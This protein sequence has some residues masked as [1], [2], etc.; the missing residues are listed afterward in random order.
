[1]VVLRCCR[2]PAQVERCLRHREVGVH[3]RRRLPQ[4]HRPDGHRREDRAVDRVHRPLALRRGSR[5][6]R[7]L[8]RC[9]G[10]PSRRLESP[11]A[12]WRRRRRQRHRRL[13][14]SALLRL[15]Q[16]TAVRRCSHELS[17]VHLARHEVDKPLP[18]GDLVEHTEE[19][20]E[21]VHKAGEVPVLDQPRQAG[22][23]GRGKQRPLQRRRG[24]RRHHRRRRLL[25]LRLR[26]LSWLRLQTG[27]G[28]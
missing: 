12:A 15:H 6:R 26:P 8:L 21:V 25:R 1:G 11:A 18:D 10:R 28:T 7:R 4:Q 14:P 27:S 23:R 19:P 16:R 24:G 20:R 17:G 9:R 22:R 5:R 13:A 2:Y 3:V